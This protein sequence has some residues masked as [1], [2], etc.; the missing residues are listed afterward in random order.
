[1]YTLSVSPKRDKKFMIITPS[2]KKIYFGAKGYSDFTLHKDVK[3]KSRY[4]KRHSV[5]QD[6]SK[7]GINS[8]G[9]WAR[10]ILW[11]KPDLMKSIIDTSKTF[12]IDILIK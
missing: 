2:G 11:N 6:W 7:N 9:F 5:N 10:W 3:R 1:M 4:I 8:A 12:K